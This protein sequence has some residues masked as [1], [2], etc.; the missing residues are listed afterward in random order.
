M[1]NGRNFECIQK[2]D[3][4]VQFS[5]GY[6][7]V[8]ARFQYDKLS[9]KITNLRASKALNPGKHG[10]QAQTSGKLGEA[11]TFVFF[12]GLKNDV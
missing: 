10:Q 3:K 11:T 7:R 9:N 5:N 4:W 2:P 1:P 12:A 6:H 8:F